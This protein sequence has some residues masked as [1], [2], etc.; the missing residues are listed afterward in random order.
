MTKNE[1]GVICNYAETE[2]INWDCSMHNWR[3]VH[4][5]NLVHFGGFADCNDMV[6]FSYLFPSFGLQSTPKTLSPVSGQD[7]SHMSAEPVVETEDT[8]PHDP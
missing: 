7:T 6:Q 4:H 5:K 2:D 3:N 8:C 1:R